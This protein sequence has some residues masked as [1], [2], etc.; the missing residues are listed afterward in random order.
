MTRGG[1]LLIVLAL[2]S[3]VAVAGVPT[4][5]VNEPGTR[6]CVAG[7]RGADLGWYSYSWN[8]LADVYVSRTAADHR[9]DVQASAWQYRSVLHF[10]DWSNT[11]WTNA[12]AGIYLY[13][14][15]GGFGGAV[16][17]VFQSESTREGPIA[18]ETY[19]T[20]AGVGAGYDDGTHGFIGAMASYGQLYRGSGSGTTCVWD[21]VITQVGLGPQGQIVDQR[22]LGCAV[23]LP[24]ALALV[25]FPTYPA[26][27]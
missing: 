21:E 16:V 3:P 25:D 13:G 9:V 12:F 5:V 26:L 10:Y 24:S 11:T 20:N 2:L 14:P 7:E 4:C 19:G 1:L 15:D 23:P 27:P 6:A 8:D 17:S 22:D 18:S